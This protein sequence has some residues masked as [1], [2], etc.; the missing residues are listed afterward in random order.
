MITESIYTCVSYDYQRYFIY[1]ASSRDDAHTLQYNG[2]PAVSIQ[3]NT[4]KIEHGK[5]VAEWRTHAT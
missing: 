1:T 5:R 3:W 4:C 2:T